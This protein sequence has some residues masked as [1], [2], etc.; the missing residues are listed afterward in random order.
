MKITISEPLKV[1]HFSAIFNHLKQFSDNV[2]VYFNSDS[3]YI[4]GLD[5]CHCCLF[6]C[7]LTSQWFDTYDFDAE[8]DQPT[9]GVN[10]G[11]L[12]KI[13][14]TRHT[15]QVIELMIEPNS[16]S[17]GI[18]L[19]G[20]TE[21]N[22]DRFFEINLIDI[23]SE[24]MEIPE[25]ETSVDLTMN[26]LKFQELITQM[27]MFN[28][29]VVFS[30]GEDNI[31]LNASGNDGSMRTEIKFDDV[32]EYAIAEDTELTQSYSLKYISMMCSF[33]KLNPSELRMG[34]SDSMPMHVKYSLYDDSYV[35]FYLAPKIEN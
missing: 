18:N 3:F 17:L 9:I 23:E 24:L 16:N 15:D 13:I 27:S 5:G 29:E 20:S 32:D 34:F 7:R 14:G 31:K 12:H 25:S 33:H 30:F 2:V 10:T 35:S 26:T 22:L 28:N 1:V 6:E 21:K 19:V 8:R 11:I 4:Q